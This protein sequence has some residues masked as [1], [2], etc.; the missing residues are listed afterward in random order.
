MAWL[1]GCCFERVDS[2]SLFIDA[3]SAS[4][5]RMGREEFYSTCPPILA[6]SRLRVIVTIICVRSQL[7]V[8]LIYISL[9]INDAQLRS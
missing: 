7:I 5:P 4:F 2:S 3:E 1:S 6:L 9:E 8:L